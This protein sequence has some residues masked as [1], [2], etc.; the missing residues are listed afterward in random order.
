MLG[1]IHL[2]TLKQHIAKAIANVEPTIDKYPEITEVTKHHIYHYLSE[3]N[4]IV[5]VLENIIHD[6]KDVSI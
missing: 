1:L 5:K 6:I 3:I 4:I 2:S